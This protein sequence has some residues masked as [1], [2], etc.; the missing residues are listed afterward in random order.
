MT[1]AEAI[2]I[3]SN[4]RK[5]AFKKKVLGS[6]QLAIFSHHG[7]NPIGTASP[8]AFTHTGRRLLPQAR[9]QKVTLR[10]IF[11]GFSGG[12]RQVEVRFCPKRR[13]W[14]DVTLPLA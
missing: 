2:V 7:I 9:M 14:S 3:V 13:T 1:S 5:R 6:T 11:D 4:I 10:V 12:Y 8:D